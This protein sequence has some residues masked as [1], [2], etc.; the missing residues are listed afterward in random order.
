[1]YW[2]AAQTSPESI[3]HVINMSKDA[4]VLLSVGHGLRTHEGYIKIFKQA[5][6]A[7]IQIPI[8]SK[9]LGCGLVFCRNNGKHG[10]GTQCTKMIGYIYFGRKYPKCPRIYLPNPKSSGFQWWKTSLG[11]RSPCF[12][13]FFR[14][15][16]RTRSCS[17]TNS[18]MKKPH[19]IS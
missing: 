15:F 7:Q 8:P 6:F 19:L 12:R 16:C 13:S 17:D 1:M 3:F 10:Q 2:P 9:C 18:K 5:S 11:V 14:T 4:S